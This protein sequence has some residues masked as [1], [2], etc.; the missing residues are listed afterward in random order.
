MGLSCGNSVKYA[1]LKEVPLP[2]WMCF[3]RSIS[4]NALDSILQGE[5]VVD[6]GSGGGLDC[7]LAAQK[8]ACFTPWPKP[9]GVHT[10]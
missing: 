4:L 2:H 10:C 5:V 8:G 1:N 6:L 3:L 9:S 7:F